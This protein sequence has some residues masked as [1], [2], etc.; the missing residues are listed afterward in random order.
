MQAKHIEYIPG[1][2]IDLKKF[3]PNVLSDEDKIELRASLE[4]GKDDILFLSVGE[5][6]PR[7]NHETAIKALAKLNNPK[8]KYFICGIGRL[9]KYL[10]NLIVTLGVLVCQ[11]CV[12]KIL[13]N[14]AGS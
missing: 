14:F 12:T 4:V 13:E 11:L 5:M 10:T 6:I 1:V 8:V 9:E 2:R 7:K 3:T